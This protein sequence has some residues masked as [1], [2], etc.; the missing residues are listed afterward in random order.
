MAENRIS[1]RKKGKLELKFSKD[2]LIL[3]KLLPLF[4][5]IMNNVSI[6]WMHW[7]VATCNSLFVS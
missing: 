1:S 5:K 7:Q 4:R 2:W 3:Y 6:S